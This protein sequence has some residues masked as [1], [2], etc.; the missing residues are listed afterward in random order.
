MLPTYPANPFRP[1]D[2]PHVRH[3]LVRVLTLLIAIHAWSASVAMPP[4]ACAGGDMAVQDVAACA[5]GAG[6]MACH[7]ATVD[8]GSPM[9]GMTAVQCFATCAGMLALPAVSR[10]NIE[11]AAGGRIAD[12]SCEQPALLAHDCPKPPPRLSL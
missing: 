10:I 6:P 3:L 5:D 2:A 1:G 12:R 7:R 9:S 4:A 11:H 8:S